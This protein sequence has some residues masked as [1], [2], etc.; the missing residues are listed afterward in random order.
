MYRKS[1]QIFSKKIYT[2]ANKR[3][4]NDEHHL[5]FNKCK[6]KPLKWIQSKRKQHVSAKVWTIQTMQLF[7]K[8]FGR[9]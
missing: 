6:F 3:R 4:E 8:K 5:S 7:W 1:E 9:F 2:K